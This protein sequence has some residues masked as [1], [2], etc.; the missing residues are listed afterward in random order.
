VYARR[1]TGANG[2]LYYRLELSNDEYGTFTD[3]SVGIEARTTTTSWVKYSAVWVAT[4]AFIKPMLLLNYGG[5]AGYIE[6]QDIRVEEMVGNDLIVDGSIT[7]NKITAGTITGTEIQGGSVSGDKITAGTLNADRI[8]AGTIN[9][10][11]LILGAVTNVA[12]LSYAAISLSDPVGATETYSGCS[13][14]KT[15]SGSSIFSNFA[16][17]VEFYAPSSGLA[18]G[19]YYVMADIHLCFSTSTSSPPSISSP[20]PTVANTVFHLTL[21]AYV[22][23]GQYISIPLNL[24]NFVIGNSYTGNVRV[25][26]STAN[27]QIQKV[28]SP[29]TNYT[30]TSTQLVGGFD[31]IEMRV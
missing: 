14:N 23:P 16:G 13:L 4:H 12:S 17:C 20:W 21:P 18:A 7:A 27:I 25:W 2:T 24:H 22:N 31:I 3:T 28:V 26:V 11:R 30:P 5:N 9:T 1:D 15:I 8:Q 6:A 29:F 19:S 10:D